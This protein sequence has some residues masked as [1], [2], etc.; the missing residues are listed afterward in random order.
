MYLNLKVKLFETFTPRSKRVT[1]YLTDTYYSTE[2]WG[3]IQRNASQSNLLIFLDNSGVWA[4]LHM[5]VNPILLG[6]NSCIGANLCA[7][8]VFHQ[9]LSS[10][11]HRYRVTLSTKVRKTRGNEL[12]LFVF[13]G[14]WPLQGFLPP[15]WQLGCTLGCSSHP[16][17]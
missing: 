14:I 7:P 6:D 1:L 5:H 10:H 12:A 8:Q 15:N 9:Y 16:E 13:V 4:S 17:F 11:Q 3:Y 2:R